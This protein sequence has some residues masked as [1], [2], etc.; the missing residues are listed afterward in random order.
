MT[1]QYTVGV[2]KTV[3]RFKISIP[4]KITNVLFGFKIK[5]TNV[6]FG[7]KIKITNVLFGFKIISETMQKLDR[8]EITIDAVFEISSHFI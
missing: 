4:V 7:F 1:I 3:Q 5:I 8:E 6:L 2:G